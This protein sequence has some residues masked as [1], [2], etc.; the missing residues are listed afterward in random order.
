MSTCA[1]DEIGISQLY[2][3]IFSCQTNSC[4]RSMW[5]EL[6]YDIS[7]ANEYPANRP[8]LSGHGLVQP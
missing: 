5:S 4:H 3:Y 6:G 1:C 8:F 7:V 2:H